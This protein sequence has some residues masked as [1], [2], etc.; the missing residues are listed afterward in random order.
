ML[1]AGPYWHG[2]PILAG[3]ITV[4]S[5]SSYSEPFADTSTALACEA[6]GPDAHAHTA[7]QSMCEQGRCRTSDTTSVQ[8]G[9]LRTVVRAERAVP[10]TRLSVLTQMAHRSTREQLRVPELHD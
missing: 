3:V 4:L 6:R 7:Q 5:T 2:V 1:H 8:S 10:D 9:A